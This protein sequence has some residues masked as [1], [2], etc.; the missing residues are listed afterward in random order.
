MK[1]SWWQLRQEETIEEKWH[2]TEKK[3]KEIFN[4]MRVEDRKYKKEI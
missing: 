3:K 4:R 2:E 1:F